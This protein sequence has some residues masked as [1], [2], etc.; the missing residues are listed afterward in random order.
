[1]RYEL[2]EY[3]KV[4]SIFFLFIC[5]IVEIILGP[6]DELGRVG[7]YSGGLLVIEHVIWMLLCLFYFMRFFQNFLDFF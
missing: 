1:M 6:N 2:S 5:L 3:M 4:C 7:L